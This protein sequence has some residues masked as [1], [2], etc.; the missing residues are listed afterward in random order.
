MPLFNL[1]SLLF[2]FKNVWWTIETELNKGSDLTGNNSDFLY[3]RGNE[4]PKINI[5][6]YKY[7]SSSWKGQKNRKMDNELKLS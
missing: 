5:I 3:S 6:E 7:N 1:I 4:S 2:I